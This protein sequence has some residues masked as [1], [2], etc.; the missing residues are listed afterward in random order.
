MWGLHLPKPDRRSTSV[1][2][3]ELRMGPSRA[4]RVS[5]TGSDN[6]PRHKGRSR[7]AAPC[8]GR[9]RPDD[10]SGASGVGTSG[11]SRRGMFRSRRQRLLDCRC[12]GR[13]RGSSAASPVDRSPSAV[14]QPRQTTRDSLRHSRRLARACRRDQRASETLTHSADVLHAISR[15]IQRCL[16]PCLSSRQGSGR[17][18]TH[19]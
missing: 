17:L 2:C 8:Q 16:G 11:P 15:G 7:R 3:S 14:A 10:L 18:G 9:R 12:A 6:D 19:R 4:S 5:W 13:G 1:L